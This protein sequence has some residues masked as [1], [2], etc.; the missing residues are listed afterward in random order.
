MSAMR[1][2]GTATSVDQI[3]VPSG[4]VAR[5]AQSACFLA[6]H[7]LSISFSL[8]AEVNVLH[9]DEFATFFAAAMLLAMA[10]FAPENLISVLAV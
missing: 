5:Q 6:D 1:D 9:D 2:I 8:L 10:S 3:W 4:L 7:R